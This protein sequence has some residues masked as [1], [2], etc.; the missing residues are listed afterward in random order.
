MTI[1]QELQAKLDTVDAAALD[2]VAGFIDDRARKIEADAEYAEGEAKARHML[3]LV[4]E[5][6]ADWSEEEAFDFEVGVKGI[7]LRSADPEANAREARLLS[8]MLNNLNMEDKIN[9]LLNVAQ[10][11]DPYV[12]TALHMV[13]MLA[14]PMTWAQERAFDIGLVSRLWD[15][16][17]RLEKH[18]LAAFTLALI[19]KIKTADQELHERLK[20]RNEELSKEQS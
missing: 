19:D 10:G 7:P 15:K 13:K 5:F 14:S 1:R 12:L 16:H 4:R 9:A 18:E 8:S 20:Q 17:D 6:A 11:R 2:A 3:G